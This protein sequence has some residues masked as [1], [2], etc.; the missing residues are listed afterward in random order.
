[1]NNNETELLKKLYQT[2][3]KHSSYQILPSILKPYLSHNDIITSSRFEEERMTYLKKHID[4]NGKKVLDIG[5]NTGFFSFESLAAGAKEVVYYE[6]NQAHANF[7]KVA[8]DTL[9]QNIKVK[10]EYL[11]FN[12]Y[13]PGEPFDI[14]LLLNV[15]HHFG[16]DY[17][18]QEATKLNAKNKMTESIRYFS[19]R[20]TYLVLQIGFCWKGDR[21]QLLFENGTKQEMIDFVKEVLDDKW[22]LAAVGIAEEH[23]EKTVY[24]DVDTNN[25]HRDDKLGEF[26]NRPILI[27]Q[28]KEHV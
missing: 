6:G 18:N 13:I 23:N 24:K 19:G 20:T 10:N 12:G 7:V 5:G 16:D 3:S 14:V 17:G 11:D 22:S 21:T 4:F 15:L 28:S 2:T 27:L 26:R 25:I 9:H 8:A 1:M